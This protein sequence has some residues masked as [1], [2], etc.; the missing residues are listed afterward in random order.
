MNEKYLEAVDIVCMDCAYGEDTCDT[1]PV[2][3]TILLIQRKI[4]E[5]EETEKKCNKYANVSINNDEQEG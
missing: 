2:R 1:C 4:K 5:V 3:N